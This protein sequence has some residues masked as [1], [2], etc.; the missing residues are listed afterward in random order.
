[1][2]LRTVRISFNKEAVLFQKKLVL[3]EKKQKEMEEKFAQYQKN[4]I[5]SEQSKTLMAEK[6]MH[7]NQQILS[8]SAEEAEQL[9][10]EKEAIRIREEE[11]SRKI[12]L[13]LKIK[14]GI[15][16]K[17]NQILN[18]KKVLA[19][20]LSGIQEVQDTL[21]AEVKKLDA[22]GAAGSF[23]V[24][25]KNG[26]SLTGE[27]ISLQEDSLE[28]KVA[29]GVICLNRDQV[30]KIEKM[31]EKQRI[32]EKMKKENIIARDWEKTILKDE[33]AKQKKIFTGLSGSDV[34]VHD[35]RIYVQGELF[36]IKGMA[37]GIE[38]PKT[39]GGMKAFHKIP[40]PVF[41]KDFEMMKEAGVNVIRTYEPVNEAILDLARKN[42]IRVIETVCFPNEL[43]DFNS[44]I[45][46]KYHLEKAVETIRGHKKHPSILMW[47]LWNDAPWVWGEIGSPFLRQGRQNIHDFLKK[48]HDAVKLE[49]PSHPITASN[50]P[51]FEGS[52]IGFDFLDV[53]GFNAYVGGM[54]CYVQEDAVSMIHELKAISERY[55]KPVV[56]LE[57]G[58]STNLNQLDQGE[59]LSSQ[60]KTIGESVSGVTIFQWADGWNKAGFIDRQDDNREEHWGIVTGYREPKSGYK[61]ITDIFHSIPTKSKGYAEKKIENHYS[62]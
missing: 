55:H 40:W 38:Y 4:L 15:E 10:K 58:F 29:G 6:I 5:E 36:Y 19:S 41:E 60:I 61:M 32:E 50:V 53:L 46:L 31:N 44:P 62:I 21:G 39:P 9:K 52:D 14:E 33:I 3:Y 12:I 1:D 23:Q 43:T 16:H 27:L 45:H 22:F 7:L 30:I 49:D 20:E 28:L 47:A 57:T 25:L 56:I 2:Q 13:S 24:V 54:D 48:I 26:D 42:N 18:E 35:Q 17:L 59:V 37:Y 51:G 11:V 34:S 8:G